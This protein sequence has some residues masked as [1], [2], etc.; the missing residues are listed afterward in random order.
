M[1]DHLSLIHPI[2]P[3][4]LLIIDLHATTASAT[5]A[6]L[7]FLASSEADAIYGGHVSPLEKPSAKLSPHPPPTP[8]AKPLERNGVLVESAR[9]QAEWSAELQN[10]LDQPPSS[11]PS[12]LI[13][14][15]LLF[16]CIFAA[17]AWFGRIQ[18]VSRAQGRL[19]PQGEVY[20]VQ[21][22]VQGEI[23]QITVEEG[24]AIEAGQVIA[25]LDNRLAEAEVDRLTQSLASYQLQL[26]ET[27]GLI[28]RTRS[29]LDIRRVI[30]QAE[31]Q[32][33]SVAINQTVIKAATQ[34]Q[35]L[36]QLQSRTV[37]YQSRL[38]RLQPLSEVGAVSQEFIFEAEQALQEQQLALTQNQ[39]DLQQSLSE[40]ERL[41]AELTQRQAQG[42]QSQLETQQRLQQLAV[43]LTQL[44]AKISETETLLK[45]ADTKLKQ[46]FLYAPVSGTVSSLAVRNIGEVAQPGQTIAEIA[47][48]DAP[49]V[50]SAL[51]PNR[52]AG[53][54]Q[55][56]MPVQIKVDAFPYQE[57]GIVS[58]SVV[59]ISPDAIVDEKLGLVYR[60]EIALEQKTIHHV[61]Q[62]VAFKAGQTASAEIVTR[63]R[64]IAD[65][66]LDPIKKLQEGVN[67]SG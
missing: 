31:L 34:Q 26:I 2:V 7:V 59:A 57:Y 8:T 63:Q 24:A 5:A 62:L 55:V 45:A 46:M 20:K 28:D 47:P 39:G 9:G 60:V 16:S 30:A 51:L 56:G 44:Q 42:Q 49:L 12:R 64:R 66:L 65:I 21:P 23:A 17:W 14:A 18:E 4:E 22:A 6:E 19:V 36:E 15:G 58:G 38:T 1:T 43:E 27:R 29:E 50:L 52:E 40:A 48:S 41:Q 53:F 61:D 32:A 3:P 10:V 25:I 67:L 33:Q 13:A 11:L 35:M 54:V 37:A